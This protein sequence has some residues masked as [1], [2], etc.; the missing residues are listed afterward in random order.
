MWR[1]LRILVLLFILLNVALGS[2]LARARSTDWDRA[3]YVAVHLVDG[4][5]SVASADHIAA[6]AALD[7]AALDEHFADIETFFEH[8]A[9][10]HGLALERPVEIVFAGVIDDRPPLPPA[11]GGIPAVMAWS[12][13][14][15]WWAWRHDDYDGLKDADVYVLFHDPEQSPRLAHSLGLQKGLIG[16]VNAFATSRMT[17]ENHVVIAH[18]LLHMVGASDK[19]DAG[20]NLPLF[21][22]GY[23]EPQREPLY[24]Q[25]AAEIMAGRIPQS[26]QAAVPPR[27]LAAVVLGPATAREIGWLR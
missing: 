23:A 7:R 2:W 5:G 15:R 16:V 12:L 6:I 20:D 25:V 9:A 19:Y 22:V 4:D 1:N 24:P 17:A 27:N 8:E 14:L 26:A 10:R 13:R 3:L 21:P 18:E 11:G